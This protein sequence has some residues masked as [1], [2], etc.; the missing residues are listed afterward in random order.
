M[1]SCEFWE[2]SKNTGRLLLHI[3]L[4]K[5]NWRHAIGQIRFKFCKT[6][7]LHKS[8]FFWCCNFCRIPRFLWDESFLKIGKYEEIVLCNTIVL[9]TRS[10]YLK[11]KFCSAL[12]ITREN[13][14]EARKNFFLR[15][16]SP[17]CHLRK[18]IETWSKKSRQI[19]LC[20][21]KN[22]VRV[23]SRK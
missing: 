5:A 20:E 17:N 3:N 23:F 15:F 13:Q 12:R 14:K 11:L 7:E 8:I 9:C 16:F 10:L 21:K 19:C 6:F 1:F 2:I 18:S 22:R 4:K